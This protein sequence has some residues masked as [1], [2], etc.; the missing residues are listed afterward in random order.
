MILQ[1]LNQYYETLCA[2]GELSVPGWDD[3]FKVSF[4][5]DLSEEGQ[6]RR[7]IDFREE[8][9]S[10]K[11]PTL[12]PKRM[13]VPAHATRTAG[14]CANFLCDNA[15]YMLG[16]GGKGSQEKS[17]KCFA[18]TAALHRQLLSPVEAP[19]AR[20]IL[21]FFRS[22]NPEADMAHPALAPY[23]EELAK[24]SNLIFCYG[25]IP[26]SEIT[27]IQQAWQESYNQPDPFA[28][29]GHCLVTGRIASVAPT[30]PQ[31][32]GVSGAQPTGASLVS[33][34]T[35]ACCSHGHTQGY[36]APVG[37]RTA[38]A[39]TA[40]LNALLADRSR[41]R[42]LGDTTLVCWAEH[43]A[44]VYQDI[45]LWALFGG[46]EPVCEDSLDKQETFYTL[47]LSA[48]AA[49]L[50]VRFFC[51]DS[52]GSVLRRIEQHQ[53]DT[54]LSSFDQSPQLPLWRLLSE[55]VNDNSRSKSPS[56]QLAGEVLR[57]VLTEAPYPATLIT[58]VMQRIRGDRR[59]TGGRAALIKG[60]YTRAT[61]AFPKEVLTVDGNNDS[62][63]IPY[64]LGRLFS[65]YEQIQDRA[66]PESQRTLR[67]RYFSAAAGTPSRIFP[68]LSQKALQIQLPRL[69]RSY[70]GSAIYYETLLG[71]LS[72]RI[73]PSYPGS[74]SLEEQGAFCLGYYFEN[75]ARYTPKTP[76]ATEE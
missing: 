23:L 6:L 72:C 45:F 28:P 10:R 67:D 52:F 30:H 73:G 2:K 53:K 18:A 56:P 48:N 35:H 7:L 34:N 54:A 50:S 40:A 14:I 63:H 27:A 15:A 55:T 71:E 43:G 61:S 46:P 24:G 38:F 29:K 70:P 58:A 25:G 11:T 33:F 12:V 13:R 3:G 26:A 51:Q 22:W 39:Y 21:A 69:R 19:A 1:G 64:L 76:K 32:K 62:N 16:I 20:A 65:V 60:Y 8:A 9:R 74:L 49:R 47:G 17:L 75:H 36:N 57:S 41:C 37:Q 42:V 44:H 5:L 31:I 68:L 59:I 4:G 66:S